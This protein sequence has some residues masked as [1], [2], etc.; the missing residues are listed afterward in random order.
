MSCLDCDH[1]EFGRMPNRRC[2]LYPDKF[3]W[4]MTADEEALEYEGPTQADECPDF[5]V[6]REAEIL[7]I[8]DER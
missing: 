5:K 2:P 1:V 6:Y 4:M 3:I 7:M 8:W